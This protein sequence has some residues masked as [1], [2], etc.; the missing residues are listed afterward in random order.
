MLTLH[1]KAPFAAFRTFHTGSFRPTALFIPPSTAYGLI[2]NLA[3]VESRF[4]DGKSTMT[5]MNNSLPNLR[6]AMVKF[7]KYVIHVQ[8]T[9]AM[10]TI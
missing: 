9:S 10:M 7:Q 1:I 2:L 6:L 5:L 3:G 8:N 4:D